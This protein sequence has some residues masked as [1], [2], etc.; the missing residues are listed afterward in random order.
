[1]AEKK[2][3]T[4]GRQA[5]TMLVIALAGILILTGIISLMA[6]GAYYVRG[7]KYLESSKNV[8]NNFIKG[9]PD[10][11]IIYVKDSALYNN[12]EAEPVEET[13]TTVQKE[14]EK[15]ENIQEKIQELKAI[16]PDTVGFIIIDG[17]DI[18][19]P[20]VQS[21]N[22][23]YYLDHNF[24]GKKDRRGCIFA[25]YRNDLSANGEPQNIVLYGHNMK[26]G[27]MFGPLK[28]YND[29]NFYESHKTV[30]LYTMKGELVYNINEARVCSEKR[31]ALYVKVE[32]DDS[33]QNYTLTLVTC[34]K[35]DDRM[36]ILGE[37][38]GDDNG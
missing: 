17:T 22:N 29:K 16:N 18:Q 33:L 26:D 1:M 19:Y 12:I 7:T 2:E 24:E 4:K 27:T 13:D 31:A 25:D 30:R 21:V 6:F 36:V 10:E 20:V 32:N 11:S 8:A 37:Q 34:S 14:K 15:L 38:I 5:Y 9:L 23:D 3:K 28:K 35:G